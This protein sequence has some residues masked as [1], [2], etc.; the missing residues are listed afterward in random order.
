MTLNI[1]QKL[2]VDKTNKALYGEIHSPFS[3]IEEMTNILPKD[4]FSNKDLR[5]LDPGCGRGYFSIYVYLG[6]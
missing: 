4:V 3:L 6:W 1:I 2:T 5:W